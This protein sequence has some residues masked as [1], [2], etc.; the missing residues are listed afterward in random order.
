M[1]EDSKRPPDAADASGKPIARDAGSNSPLPDSMSI[2]LIERVLH[3]LP[4]NIF[5][6]DDQ[7]RYV[8]ATK[9]WD[10]IDHE[11]EGWTIRGKTD[12]EIRK[13]QE[14]ARKAYEEDLRILETGQGTSYVIMENVNGKVEYLELIKSP[15]FD[16]DG[17]VIGIVG[18]INDVTEKELM[19]IE[20]ERLA[21]TDP[22]TG[23]LNRHRLM[24]L[25]D[26]GLEDDQYPA[27]V[28]MADC[29]NLKLINDRFGHESGN[30]FI[31][32]TA[33]LL[34]S[35]LPEDSLIFRMGGD[36]FVAVITRADAG[37]AERFAEKLREGQA[38]MRINGT[39]VSVSVGCDT[40]MSGE[41]DF[42]FVLR[43]ADYLMYEN[44]GGSRS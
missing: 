39:P 44:K 18:L 8:F 1:T 37:S 25:L 30:E 2:D 22:L 21:V 43:R 26:N 9:Y 12:F 31:C 35:A 33:D 17:T 20:L 42:A 36:E 16:D 11:E 15:V 6:K 41:D 23:L 28:V 14:N 13:N 34:R 4:S 3:G 32:M 38:N 19:R 27:A 24:D 7:C 5:L 40:L 29:D 10:H